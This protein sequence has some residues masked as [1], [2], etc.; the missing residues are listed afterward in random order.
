[1]DFREEGST[2]GGFIELI[3]LLVDEA[4]ENGTLADTWGAEDHHFCL[5]LFGHFS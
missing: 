1:M 2:E 3:E 5:R 4:K